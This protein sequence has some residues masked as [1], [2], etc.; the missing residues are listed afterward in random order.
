MW[1]AHR[2]AKTTNSVLERILF[3]F[4]YVLNTP[5]DGGRRGTEEDGGRRRKKEGRRTK[6]ETSAG[7]EGRGGL[8]ELDAP[9]IPPIP[10]ERKVRRRVGT[11]REYSGRSASVLGARIIVNF[12]RNEG[13]SLSVGAL[14]ASRT[15]VPT[16]LAL[17]AVSI[18][19]G[20]PPNEPTRPEQHTPTGSSRRAD[21]GLE[22]HGHT[23]IEEHAD[24][25]VWMCVCRD[26]PRAHVGLRCGHRAAVRQLRRR[27]AASAGS[28]VGI[29]IWAAER[30][31]AA[32]ADGTQR[33]RGRRPEF[34]RKRRRQHELLGEEQLTSLDALSGAHVPAPDAAGPDSWHGLA[35]SGRHTTI[36]TVGTGIT[37]STAGSFGPV[38]LAGK[39]GSSFA[40]TIVWS[41][42]TLKSKLGRQINVKWVKI[43]STVAEF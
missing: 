24:V 17:E 19:R 36:R 28:K 16:E 30:M 15:R 42:H 26:E 39:V 27:G 8:D 14:G 23:G 13:E 25:S 3:E 10:A 29:W 35:T 43:R 34:G 18:A 21:V 40:T 9:A 12:S 11:A 20:A 2:T 1:M 38:W 6:K 7:R 33:A 37:R 32:T 31:R 5:E 22:Q 41:Q 4:E